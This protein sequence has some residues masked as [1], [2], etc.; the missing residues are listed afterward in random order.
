MT[1]NQI[2]AMMAAEKLILAERIRAA[3]DKREL[4]GEPARKLTGLTL[5]DI[6][7]VRGQKIERFTLDRLIGVMLKLGFNVTIRVST[8][9]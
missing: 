3:L 2:D 4:T 1:P 9:Q 7:R 5:A 8:R 6:S